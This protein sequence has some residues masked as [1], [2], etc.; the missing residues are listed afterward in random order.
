MI[1]NS[2]QWL[3]IQYINNKMD[4]EYIANRD[5]IATSSNPP[6]LDDFNE[7]LNIRDNTLNF[8]GFNRF[9]L[10]ILGMMAP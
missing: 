7:V 4:P 10:K 3:S 1:V 5:G 9:L 2:R 8:Y 6:L